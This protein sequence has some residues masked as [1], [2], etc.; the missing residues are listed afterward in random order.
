VP[1]PEIRPADH[2]DLPVLLRTFGQEHFFT[3]AFDRQH[4]GRG[5]LLLAWI[6]RESGR[7]LVGDVYLWLEA[8]EEPEIQDEFPGVPLLQHLEVARPHW[9]RGFG[10]A[11]V[12]AAEEWLSKRG[13]PRVVLGVRLDNPGARRLYRRLGY[14]EWTRPPIRNPYVRHR[15][16]GE[17]VPKLEIYTVLVKDL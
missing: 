13:Y 11:I 10:T 14:R 1:T 2:A 5:Q 8:A 15:D 6:D 12:T 7:E 17:I 9:N 3:N 4:A 16:T